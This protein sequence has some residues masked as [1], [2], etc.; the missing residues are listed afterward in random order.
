MSTATRVR[1]AATVLRERAEPDD[2]P[3]AAA[4]AD[5]LE[6]LAGQHGAI[7]GYQLPSDHPAMRIA[8][9]ILGGRAALNGGGP[10]VP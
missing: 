7:E 2:S 5:W 6:D 3:L 4:L 9:L 1:E 10:D 8:D